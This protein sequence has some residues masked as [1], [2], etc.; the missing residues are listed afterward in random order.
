MTPYVG[1]SDRHGSTLIYRGCIGFI[2]P[3]YLYTNLTPS[4]LFGSFL[5][6]PFM[7]FVS[8]R[9]VPFAAAATSAASMENRGSHLSF[10]GAIQQINMACAAV[11]LA[12]F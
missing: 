6:P 4:S 2:D 11:C 1:K 10:L 3:L 9:M 8:G 12:G 5:S 7:V